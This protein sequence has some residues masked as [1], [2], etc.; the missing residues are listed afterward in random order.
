MH[1]LTT[2]AKLN[3]EAAEASRIINA[4]NPAAKPVENPGN[5][6]REHLANARQNIERIL[7]G[8][9]G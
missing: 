5:A 9:K 6:V 3:R 2:I 4:H 7:G 1:P 8:A